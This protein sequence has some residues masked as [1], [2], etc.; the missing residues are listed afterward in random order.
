MST[1]VIKRPLHVIYCDQCRKPEYAVMSE[2]CRHCGRVFCGD[3]CAREHLCGGRQS[4]DDGV[5]ERVNVD[6]Q[7]EHEARL[8][9]RAAQP[10]L[11]EA[12]HM[13]SVRLKAVNGERVEHFDTTLE[14]ADKLGVKQSAI[15]Y[16][17]KT[18][19]TLRSG[20]SFSW[21]DE[22]G[23]PTKPRP[24]KKPSSG[25][26]ASATR[27]KPTPI[28]QSA[29]KVAA[30]APAAATGTTINVTELY[31]AIYKAVGNIKDV[32]MDVRHDSVSIFIQTA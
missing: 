7:A 4:C 13:A 26:V 6:I 27:R 2:K 11:V 32:R 14:A 31:A 16:A 3:D 21:V 24:G 18:G 20:W 19:K 17:L 30:T 1:T 12:K 8:S 25:N 9:A 22:H 15:P 23:N 28:E 5:A 10:F 29:P